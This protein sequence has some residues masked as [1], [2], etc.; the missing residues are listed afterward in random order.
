M[1]LAMILERVLQYGL[2][3]IALDKFVCMCDVWLAG[4]LD[5][6]ASV[7]QLGVDKA[8]PSRIVEHVRRLPRST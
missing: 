2:V 1:R 7:E 5:T 4:G 8:V 6:G 3:N